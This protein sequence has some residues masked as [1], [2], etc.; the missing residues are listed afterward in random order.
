[1]KTLFL[2][3]FFILVTAIQA[4]AQN[5]PET[6]EIDKADLQITDCEFDK[7]AEAFKLI[8]VGS[9]EYLGR[10]PGLIYFAAKYT[11]RVRIKILKEKG[12]TYANVVIPFLAV[13]DYEKINDLVAYTYNLDDAGNVKTTK[14]SKASIYKKKINSSF[15]EMIIAFPEV[16]VGSVIEYAYSIERGLS[17][18]INDWN[19]QDRIP[20]RFSEYVVAMPT[21]L[22][23][24]AKPFATDNME[25]R[26]KESK[27]LSTIN[28]STGVRDYTIVKYYSMK[29]I[30]GLG[31]EPFMG[32]EKDYRQ[33][34]EFL[35]TQVEAYD[36]EI[37]D[38]S[39]SWSL[40]VE[41]SQKSKYFGLQLE[42]FMA[43]TLRLVEE[44]KAIPDMKTRIKTIFKHVQQ[45]MTS[46]NS[47]GILS[48]DGVEKAYDN[49]TGSIADINLLLLNL[50]IKADVKA[51]PILFSTR[52]HG[53]VNTSYPDINQ[54]N[55]VMAYVPVD[56]KYWILDAADKLSSCTL[57]PEQVVNS[58]GFLLQKP[59][60]K[61]L[62]VL[63][64]KVKYKVFTA[65]QGSINGEGKMTGDVT[66][67]C[68]G[69]AK[70]N[71]S[72]S[73]TKNK[74][75]FKQ[76]YFTVPDISVNLDDIAV[77]NITVDSLPLEQKVK[78]N[79]NLS[80]S[81]EYTSFTVNIFSGLDK[82]PFIAEQRIAD[83]DFG[84]LQEY[85]IVGSFM[86]PEG[87]SFD[88]LPENILLTMPD[89]S[90]VFSRFIA[91]SENKLNVRMSAEFKNSFYSVDNYADFREF[92]K[93]LFATLNEQ[94][95]LKKKS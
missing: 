87:Y 41:Y 67:T 53:L 94:V 7:G 80:R 21:Y 27:K 55:T 34:V 76:Q 14:V 29:N 95:V 25:T 71:R 90:I 63:E 13:D 43:K 20:A 77:N 59:G 48:Y 23:F 44:W 49:K 57:I 9:V 6:G 62:E 1:M 32:A 89:K 30:K 69:Y 24:K 12:I 11:R 42:A 39:T 92:Y 45:T 10:T 58:N 17:Y 84:Y 86:I 91:I 40:M 38:L 35:L 8:D 66:V 81:G 33:R 88:A 54:F 52:D 28:P 2:S 70:K 83:V 3:L 37:V 5:L 46:D 60:G 79:A 50:L 78:F 72:I 65:V 73:W 85:T 82:N 68:S 93:K 51:I 61:W 75:E 56:D 64:S 36:N 47:D 15:S 31:K 16:K 26:Q 18:S 4:V 22:H 74:E 19:F